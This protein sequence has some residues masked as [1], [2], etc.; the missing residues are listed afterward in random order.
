MSILHSETSYTF[1]DY[2]ELNYPTED[3]LQELGYRY[4][5]A[6]LVLP[7]GEIS[8][9]L[10]GLQAMFYRRLPHIGLT[11]ETAK[12]EAMVAPVLLELLDEIEAKLDIEYPIYV[13]ERLKGS[14]D[15]WIRSDREFLV[16]EAKKSDMERGFTQL[17]VELIAM[18]HYLAGGSAELYG[19]VTVGE[20][21][22]FGRLDRATKLVSKD[23]DAF[24]VP[25]DLEELFQVL[26]G[27]LRG[28]VVAKI[29]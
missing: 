13:N 25:L 12:R 8:H 10:A 16:V 1:S 27:I 4:E 19:A 20:L 21:W 9:P 29:E 17:A 5:F 6:K 26:V 7:H 24:R 22:R 15:Y 28:S 3:V 18:D 14:L 2:F 11:S 23:I